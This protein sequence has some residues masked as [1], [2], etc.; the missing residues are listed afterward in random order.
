MLAV[1]MMQPKTGVPLRLK[2]SDFQST[3]SDA[4]RDP[5]T[6]CHLNFAQGCHLYIARTTCRRIYLMLRYFEFSHHINW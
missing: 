6:Q 1:S 3:R 4:Y 2:L 5:R